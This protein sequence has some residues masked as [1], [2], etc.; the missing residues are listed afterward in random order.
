MKFAKQLE[1][2]AVPEWRSQYLDY[3][4]AK[5]LLKAVARALRNT[6]HFAA[7]NNSIKNAGPSPFSSL[8]DAPVRT[9]IR[10]AGTSRAAP[11]STTASAKG[12]SRSDFPTPSAQ[13]DGDAAPRTQPI[14]VTDRSPLRSTNDG[15]QMMRYGSIITS[16]PL[17][18]NE[19]LSRVKTAPSLELPFPAL[20]PSVSK[21]GQDRNLDAD[22]DQPVSPGSLETFAT[23]RQ[24]PTPA[25][26]KSFKTGSSTTAQH[27][28]PHRGLRGVFSHLRRTNSTPG[29]PT[30]NRMFSGANGTGHSDDVALEQ[31][32]ELDAKNAAFRLFLDKELLKI[33]AFYKSK[34]DEAVQHLAELRQQ[35]HVLR[36][37][38][39]QEM[40]VELKRDAPTATKPVSGNQTPAED[41]TADEDITPKKHKHHPFGKS[42][43]F[44]TGQLEHAIDRVRTGHVGE[45]SRAMGQ[46]G[47]P[48]WNAHEHDYQRKHH[49]VSYR[50]A[51]S[52]LKRAFAD[53]YRHLELIKS[54]ALLNRTAFRKINKKHDKAVHARPKMQYMDDKINKSHFVTSGVV[55]NI[56]QQVEDLYARYFERGNHKLAVGKLRQKIPKPGQHSGSVFRVG[57]L[58]TAGCILAIQALVYGLQQDLSGRDPL[59]S[60]ANYLLQ[61][62]AGYFLGV[63]LATLFALDCGLF[64]KFKI[65]YQLI[66][67]L[68]NRHNLDWKELAEIPAACMCLLGVIMLLNFQQI[69]GYAM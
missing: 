65:N 61:I 66:F 35:L 16:P 59:A 64:T 2:E 11:N 4:G 38:R 25:R 69:G 27:V 31:Y 41:E 52:S 33:E 40:A 51:K 43:D 12:R 62:Y 6:Q 14:K 34:E 8:R 68:D 13:H 54:Y 67:E 42:V 48:T 36:D 63:L 50:S 44:A 60:Q 53:Y 21:S 30:I 17:S 19:E 55:E 56:I 10:Q 28:D 58:F 32:N 57:V 22:Y 1:D 15:C 37:Q 3:K 20:D 9:L 29:R 26:T 49:E 39:A 23:T 45:T 7:S 24:P 46:L 47:T 5:K 18:A